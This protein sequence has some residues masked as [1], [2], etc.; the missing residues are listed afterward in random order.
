MSAVCQD[1]G[2]EATCSVFT[3]RSDYAPADLSG[4][5]QGHH[6]H[7]Q[8]YRSIATYDGSGL[9]EG[10]VLLDRDL[11]ALECLPHACHEVGRAILDAHQESVS[12]AEVPGH[13]AEHLE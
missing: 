3:A 7:R 13:L 2:P 11:Q 9:G 5:P 8:Q 6:S 1:L 10:V 12:E 4:C